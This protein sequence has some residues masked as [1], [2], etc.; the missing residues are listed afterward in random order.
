MGE[1]KSEDDDGGTGGV[2][3][4]GRAGWIADTAGS[5]DSFGSGMVDGC[6]GEDEEN[7]EEEKEDVMTEK[8]EEEEDQ[9]GRSG[10][11]PCLLVRRDPVERRCVMIC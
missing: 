9:S 1:A 5:S 3:G 7:E 11:L 8:N 6:D 10:R 4:H 2:Q